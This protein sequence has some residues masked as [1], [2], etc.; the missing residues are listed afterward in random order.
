[1]TYFGSWPANS[2]FRNAILKPVLGRKKEDWNLYHSFPTHT[3]VGV[4]KSG[5]WLTLIQISVTPWYPWYRAV[6]RDRDSTA[7]TEMAST[8]SQ[9]VWCKK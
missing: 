8:P 2:D 9:V 7:D 1:M 3:T 5:S 6:M 4:E